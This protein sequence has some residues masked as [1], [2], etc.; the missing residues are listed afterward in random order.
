MKRNFLCTQ[1]VLFLVLFITGCQSA[2]Q[3]QYSPETEERIRQVENNL[4]DWVKTQYDTAWSIDERMKHHNIMGTSIAVIH[5]FRLEWVKSY[6]WADVSEQRPVT[7]QTLFQAASISKSLN[8]VGVLKLAQDGKIDLQADINDYL[9]TWKFPYDSV[10][11]GKPITI[12]ALLSHTAGL[13][14]HGFPGY[15]QGDT[16]PSVQQI[17]D[18]QA[19]ANTEAVR[20][21]MEPGLNAV[22]SGGGTTITQMIVTDLTGQPYHEY[23]QKNVLDPMGMK[24]SSYMQPPADSKSE[25]L[26]TGYKPDGTPVEGKYHIYPEQAPAGLWTNPTDL[27]R[28]IIETAL[29]YNGKSDKVLT[30][31]FTKMRLEPVKEDAALGVFVAKKDSGYYF[32]HGGANEGFTCYYV[33]DVISGNGMVIMTNSDNGSLSAEVANS[34]AI[35]YGWKDYYK[36]VF[37]TVVDVD[38]SILEKYVG[39]YVAGGSTF[40]A[41]REGDKL[42]IS[43]Y[44]GMWVNVFFTSDTDFFVRESRDE[45]KF[46]TDD[47]GS[48]TGFTAGGMLIRKIE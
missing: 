13:T 34:V 38:E 16:L 12:A 42:L 11:K 3:P 17:L 1:S 29:S 31:E 28:Y 44:P 47:K 45:M 6:G 30:S 20:S 41:K 15:A 8:G 25:L 36:P 46:I 32:S 9:T 19:P 4:G 37:K 35:V 43:P 10:S 33:G 22:Y 48:V 24:A 27:G 21:F 18:G 2:K 7:E 23:M 5:D 14:V 40:T 39:Q 26:A